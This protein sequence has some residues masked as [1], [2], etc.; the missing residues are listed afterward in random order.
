MQGAD[1]LSW[2]A[3]TPHAQS[4]QFEG[5][6]AAGEYNQA[7]FGQ[8]M[9]GYDQSVVSVDSS[10]AGDGMLEVRHSDGSGTAFYD[11]TMYQ[12]PRGDYHVFEDSRGSQWYAIPGTPAV[13]RRP[14][15][16]DGKPVYDGGDLRTVN[17]ESVRY[18]TTPARFSGP[19][20]RPKDERKAPKKK[21]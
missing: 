11:R 7:L 16:E 5:G 4:P 21:N 18:K 1:G 20:Q 6:A 3:M 12:P 14:V 13:E 9:P 19:D 15:Y 10:R 2:Y 17:V 8:F